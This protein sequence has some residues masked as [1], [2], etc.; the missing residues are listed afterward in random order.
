MS[1][2]VLTG[3][4]GRIGRLLA[5]RLESAGHEVA[6]QS[7][8]ASLGDLAAAS[9]DAMAR[10]MAGS[11]IVVHLAGVAHRAAD[12]ALIDAVNR[13]AAIRLAR[14]ARKA[15]VRRFVLAS[16]IYAAS[17]PG[18]TSPFNA[19][20]DDAPHGPYGEAKRAA[21]TGVRDVFGDDAVIL[22]FAP[23]LLGPPAGG[24]GRLL[25]LSTLPVPLPFAGLRNRRSLA[26]PETALRAL[27]RS[28]TVGSGVIPVAD[29]RPV[30]AAEIVTAFRAAKGQGPGLFALPTW[31]VR[32]ALRGLGG[33]DVA[34]TL[35]E[36]FIVDTTELRT[37]GVE[38]LADSLPALRAYAS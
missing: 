12:P 20:T 37:M 32:A 27:E 38:P 9:E 15:G 16:T 18:R 25:R 28:V 31:L 10:A 19:L 17:A 33:A 13:E 22:R 4:T 7:R 21:E 36:N 26:S 29:A 1:R 5:P 2:A 6:R 11:E 23:V 35:C 34:A 3:A 24:L 30:S 14:A 8:D